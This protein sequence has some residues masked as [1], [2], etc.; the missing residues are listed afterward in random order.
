MTTKTIKQASKKVNVI[1]TVKKVE[2][3]STRQKSVIENNKL[4]FSSNVVMEKSDKVLT[5]KVVFP[6]SEFKTKVYTVLKMTLAQKKKFILTQEITVGE[7]KNYAPAIL[8]SMFRDRIESVINP[9]A[10]LKRGSYWNPIIN[11]LSKYWKD[12]KIKSLKFQYGKQ[13]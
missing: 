2:I 6:L 9:Q 11:A 8:F 12:E 4:I 13:K 3:D 1:K 5:K 7:E 10:K